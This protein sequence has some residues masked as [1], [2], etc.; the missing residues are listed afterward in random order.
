MIIAGVDIED[1]EAVANMAKAAVS[2]RMMVN[3]MMLCCVLMLRGSMHKTVQTELV[4]RKFHW[5]QARV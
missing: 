1:E 2:V 5:C 3:F 4:Y